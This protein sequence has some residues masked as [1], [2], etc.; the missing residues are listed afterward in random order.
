MP[1]AKQELH[2]EVAA[3]PTS[4][5]GGRV[6]KRMNEACK[7]VNVLIVDDDLAFTKKVEQHLQRC[8]MS[9]TVAHTPA[10]ALEICEKREPDVIIAN[11]DFDHNSGAEILRNLRDGGSI[12]VVVT[13]NHRSE[14]DL[15]A[16]LEAGADEY[17]SKPLSMRELSMRISALVRRRLANSVQNQLKTESGRWLFGGWE[18]HLRTRQLRHPSGRPVP[19][20]KGE[21]TLLVA[22]L[23]AAN[24][25]LSREFLQR[26]TRIHEDI[27]DRSVD[28]QVMR[29]RR[30]IEVDPRA[31]QIIKT[32]R[33][34]GYVFS[35]DANRAYTKSRF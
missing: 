33:G 4:T 16:W 18:L 30:K 5:R 15:L 34:I 29:L 6:E 25:P 17:L 20:T 28:V 27:F 32:A 21:Y 26:A 2:L 19:L 22:F 35:I 9:T 8:D 1:P 3:K 10:K 7:R 11:L 24:Q 13:G 12:P 31:P 14:N 23:E